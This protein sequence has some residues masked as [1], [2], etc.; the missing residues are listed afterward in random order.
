M[1][2]LLPLSDNMDKAKDTFSKMIDSAKT[3]AQ[4]VV[5]KVIEKRPT[6]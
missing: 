3:G 2:K 5:S 1:N 4:N 6:V